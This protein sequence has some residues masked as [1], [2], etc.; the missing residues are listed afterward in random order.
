MWIWKIE[1]ISVHLPKIK[2][3]D[4]ENNLLEDVRKKA[5]LWLDGNYD[6]DTK[7]KVQQD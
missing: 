4:M 5:Q 1:K 7:D 6:A 2:T 3:I